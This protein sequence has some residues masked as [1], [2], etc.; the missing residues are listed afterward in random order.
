MEKRI[1]RIQSISFGFGGYQDAQL[2]ISVTLGS[3]KE[4]WGT[5][6]FRGFWNTERDIRC[7][8][9]EDDRLKYLGEVCMWAGGILNDAKVDTLEKLVGIPVEVTFEDMRLK[10]WRVLTE[11]I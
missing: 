10:E 9:T 4:C 1:G 11:A 7:S 2:G 3:N 6:D 5:G 8:W